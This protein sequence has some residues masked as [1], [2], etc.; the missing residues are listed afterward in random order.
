MK[1][2]KDK[3]ALLILFIGTVARIIIGSIV[4]PGFDEAYYGVYANHLSW[5]YFDHPPL[6]A[7]TAGIGQWLFSS[8]SYF[9]LRFGAIL[10]FIPSCIVLYETANLLFNKK[11]AVISL[12]LIN[13]IP[14]FTVGMGAF[15]IPDNALGLFWLVFIYALAKVHLSKNDKWFLLAGACLGFA[16]LSKYHAVLL[17]GGLGWLLLFN[18]D[19]RKYFKSVYLY[20]SFLIAIVIFL[21]NIIWNYQHNW[22]SYLL[23]FGKSASGGDITLTKFL[24]GVFVQAGY[25]LPWMMIILIIVIVKTFKRKD[26]MFNWLLP[27]AVFPVLIFTLIGATRQ[28]LPHWPMPGYLSAIVLAGGIMSK[29]KEKSIEWSLVPTGAI[30]ILAAIL[31]CA[32]SIFGLIPLD[33]R[34]DI[35]LDGQG[36]EEVIKVLEEENLLNEN[37]FIF[38]N[39]WFTGGEM[40]YAADGKYLSTVLNHE[41]PH[42]FDFWYSPG[43]L[44]GK[45]GIFVSTDRYPFEPDE[46]YKDYF[47]SFELIKRLKTYRSK[48]E[49]QV[50]TI[51]YCKSLRKLY[52]SPY[53]NWENK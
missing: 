5:G 33:K 11:G 38:T 31:I 42:S 30:T 21:P 47:E 2:F 18:R 49:A 51:W 7:F 4:P 25:L 53:G 12:V 41:A 32:Q 8:N 6:V 23:Q 43:M 50:F 22:I 24:Q 16:L 17:L 46:L 39:K 10:L 35:T 9:A 40:A 19:W 36:W 26:Q 45:D 13:I 15:V 3:T 52:S 28:I 37:N 44:I 34:G 48:N 29:W 1:F 14:Y 27:F 20:S